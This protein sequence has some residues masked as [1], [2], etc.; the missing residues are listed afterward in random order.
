MAIVLEILGSAANPNSSS[1]GFKNLTLMNLTQ[2]NLSLFWT[3]HV[4]IF[5]VTLQIC[6]FLKFV[7]HFS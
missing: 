4:L 1:A 3:L 7:F 2:N 5:I 6:L